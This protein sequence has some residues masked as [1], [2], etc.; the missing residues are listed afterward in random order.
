MSTPIKPKR[1]YTAT[2]VPSGL[3]AGELAVNAADGKVWIGSSD[4]KSNVLISSLSLS[5]MAGTTSNVTE[6]SNLYYTDSRARLSLSA[7]TGISYDNKT[8]AIT[9]SSPDQTVVLT[10][11]TGI[12]TSGT[13]PNF[14]ITNSSP[15]QTVKLTSGTGISIT[16]TYPEFTIT[17]S[18]PSSGGTV[19]SVGLSLPAIFSISNS[20]VTTSGTL[21]GTLANQNPNIVFAG[22]SNGVAAAPTFRS[23]VAADIPTLNQNTTGTSANVTGIVALANGGTAANLTAVNG[24]VVYSTASALA[25]SSAGTSGQLLQSNGAA[26]PSWVASPGVPTGSLFPYA[27]SSAPT[28]YLL[29]D[30]SAVSRTT[31]ATLFGVLSTTYGAGNGSTTFNLPDL[32][33]RMPLGAG[34][35]V[36]LNASGTGAPSGTAQTA[37]TAGQWGGE[38]THLLTSSEMPQ[39][40]H[41]GVTGYMS[42]NASHAHTLQNLASSTGSTT[43][44][45]Q[46]RLGASNTTLYTNYTNTDHYHTIPYDGSSTRHATM[47][48]FIVANYII[49]T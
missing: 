24:G 47:P 45:I 8:G 10:A 29:C 35:G 12:S 49:K 31:Y 5:D 39:H 17:N 40:N 7:G 25:V 16:G 43:Y 19:T 42:A 6:G 15:D 1:S 20:P 3:S 48:P 27:G 41:T 33:G 23:L 36:G 46:D 30:G 28:G 2:S 44:N 38:E 4:G 13:Y 18:S 34:T 11:G 22:P 26:A 9:N 37:R 14:T 32:R 21:T